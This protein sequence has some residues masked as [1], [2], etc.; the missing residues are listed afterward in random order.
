MVTVIS[1]FTNFVFNSDQY[2]YINIVFFFFFVYKDISFKCKQNYMFLSMNNDVSN[3]VLIKKYY[4][5]YI[6]HLM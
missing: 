2:K 5:W 1:P 4:L 3:F 6:K